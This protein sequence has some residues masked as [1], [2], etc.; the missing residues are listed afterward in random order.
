MQSIHGEKFCSERMQTCSPLSFQGMQERG[1]AA[2]QSSV[3]QGQSIIFIDSVMGKEH[4]ETRPAVCPWQIGAPRFRSS[5][6]DVV[7]GVEERVV[8]Y[9]SLLPYMD[10]YWK[11][12]WRQLQKI[13]GLIRT[14]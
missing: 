13:G 10:E 12:T 9:L 14:D 11:L 2:V 8:E 7:L 6:V 1:A 3:A 4:F 5:L